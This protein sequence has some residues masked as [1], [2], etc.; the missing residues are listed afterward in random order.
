MAGSKRQL[1]EYTGPEVKQWGQDLGGI[2]QAAPVPLNLSLAYSVAGNALTI[3]AK[4]QG[5]SNATATLPAILNMRSATAASGDANVRSI[6]AGL[7]LVVSSGSTLG[8]ANSDS[9]WVYVYAID[10]AGTIE[11]AVSRKFFGRQG[12]VST[13][14]EGGAGGAD[15]ATVMYSTSARSNVPYLCIGRFK[16]PQTT[17]GTWAAEPS[18]Q[19]GSNFASIGATTPISSVVGVTNFPTSGQYGDLTSISL[20]A[21]NFLVCA[22]FQS[23]TNGATVTYNDFGIGLISGNSSSGLVYGDNVLEM[24]PPVA[25][26]E[27]SGAIADY[28]LSLPAAATV[29]L[30]FIAGYSV[31]TPRA[32]G[33]L[34]AVEVL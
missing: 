31:A 29:Y 8:Q 10:N 27:S 25:G 3:A 17:A 30:K 21:G 34:S 33:R 14:A 22:N 1:G 19:E 24:L 2:L 13:T 28:F 15:T 26:C 16:A 5:G 32:R 23:Q 7:S 9:R 18:S 6:E 20:G 11:L 12:I 4:Q